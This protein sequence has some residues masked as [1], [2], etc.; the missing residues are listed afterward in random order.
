MSDDFVQQRK[1]DFE[2]ICSNSKEKFWPQASNDYFNKMKE[3]EWEKIYSL[4]Y[5]NI[6]PYPADTVWGVIRQAKYLPRWLFPFGYREHDGECIMDKITA[7]SGFIVFRWEEWPGYNDKYPEALVS[8]PIVDYC[9][10][11]YIVIAVF[12]DTY[13]KMSIHSYERYTTTIKVEFTEYCPKSKG[14]LPWVFSSSIKKEIKQEREHKK[15]IFDKQFE[16]MM[17]GI[18]EACYDLNNSEI[19]MTDCE[20]FCYNN[21]N[22][23]TVHFYPNKDGRKVPYIGHYIK[24]NEKI[25]YVHP[26]DT[27]LYKDKYH[28]EIGKFFIVDEEYSKENYY[29]E[30][31]VSGYIASIQKQNGD[32][33]ATFGERFFLI[34]K[35]LN[36]LKRVT[37]DENIEYDKT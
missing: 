10:N 18:K 22:E 15:G 34:C 12:E 29:I 9:E 32:S 21:D 24:K 19:D 30:S 33:I 4:P 3:V 14:I 11:D 5:K 13:L 8:K 1:R 20:W 6:I 17:K 27:R 26:K 37:G 7:G 35:T 31:K 2:E 28:Y 23:G 25:G 36:A 16:W